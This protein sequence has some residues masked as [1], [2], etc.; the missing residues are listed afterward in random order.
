MILIFD[1]DQIS[2]D[3]LQLWLHVHDQYLI[4]STVLLYV[5]GS[6]EETNK[7]FLDMVKARSEVKA[8]E[9]EGILEIVRARN[10]VKAEEAK[11]APDAGIESDA[12][13]TAEED[14]QERDITFLDWD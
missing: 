1:L 8:E 11:T 6:E 2:S 7:M 13:P 4:S 9:K 3:L 10:T 12:A 5:Q 14:Q